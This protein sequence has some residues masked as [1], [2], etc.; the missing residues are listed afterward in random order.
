MTTRPLTEYEKDNIAREF[1]YVDDCAVEGVMEDGVRKGTFTIFTGGNMT[2]K[3]TFTWKIEGYA[4]KED[5]E[6]QA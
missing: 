2:L 5:T 3:G 4:E 6:G 1:A